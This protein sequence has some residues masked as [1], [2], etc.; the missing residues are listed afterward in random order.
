MNEQQIKETRAKIEKKWQEEGKPK[1]FDVK[2]AL[3]AEGLTAE[4]VSQVAG[5]GWNSDKDDANPS[6]SA[7][8]QA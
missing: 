1:D 2:A 8:W 4:E 6:M 7:F 3:E 5:G